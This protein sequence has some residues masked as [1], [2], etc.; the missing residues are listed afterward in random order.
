MLDVLPGSVRT[1]V[2]PTA[3]LLPHQFIVPIV[4]LPDPS[5][6]ISNFAPPF[7]EITPEPDVLVGYTLV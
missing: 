2:S 7:P 3:K 4:G 6:V 5:V 1:I